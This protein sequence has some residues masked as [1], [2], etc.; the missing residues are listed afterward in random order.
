MSLQAALILSLFLH[1]AWL[2]LGGLAQHGPF[3]E[4]GGETMQV[5]LTAVR[6]A[7]VQPPPETRALPPRPVSAPRR[8]E[9]L[10][11]PAY[12]A[13]T[14]ERAKGG[15]EAMETGR[16]QDNVSAAETLSAVAG[17]SAVA[18][19]VRDE[20]SADGLRQY[21]QALAREARRHRQYPLLARSR[22]WEGTVEVRVQ[23]S[24]GRG[25]VIALARSSGYRLLD[26]R[27]LEMMA[28]AILVAVLPESLRGQSFSVP[29]PV[30]F[31]L[32]E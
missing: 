17:A 9:V 2:L 14:S 8:Q 7:A 28:Q 24:D 22:G 19:P 6:G 30:Q 29:V 27:A 1:G 32:G 11:A 13:A 23:V 21:R 4:Q 18:A 10:T 15:L 20:V 31:V 26:E 16:A 5:S 12:A 3:Q 25:P